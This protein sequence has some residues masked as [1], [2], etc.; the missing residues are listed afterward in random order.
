MEDGHLCVW[1]V[2]QAWTR[3]DL[4]IERYAQGEA[5]N[6]LL[7]PFPPRAPGILFPTAASARGE[8]LYPPPRGS[9]GHRPAAT[10]ATDSQ[11]CDLLWSA[12][13]CGIVS[14]HGFSHNDLRLWRW[15]EGGGRMR[16]IPASTGNTVHEARVLHLAPSPDRS[17]FCSLAA[18]EKACV[19]KNVWPPSSPGYVAARR[20]P[21]LRSKSRAVPDQHR[22]SHPFLRIR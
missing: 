15:D 10:V 9:T 2:H 1:D 13:G 6:L 7:R 8:A 5:Q 16:Q 22:P 21:G 11:I 18:D 17:G 4:T 3:K 14:A 19:W 20:R 12:D